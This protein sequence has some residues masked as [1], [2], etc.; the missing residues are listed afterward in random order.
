MSNVSR[1]ATA[2][3]ALLLFLLSPIGPSAADDWRCTCGCDPCGGELCVNY[4]GRCYAGE[5]WRFNL[6]EAGKIRKKDIVNAIGSITHHPEGIRVKNDKRNH[7]WT[8]SYT[9]GQAYRHKTRWTATLE[10]T[11]LSGGAWSGVG[12]GNDGFQIVFRANAH[13]KGQLVALHPDVSA[14]VV[15]TFSLPPEYRGR[16]AFTLATNYDIRTAT[17]SLSVDDTLVREIRLPDNGI[18]AIST[19]YRFCIETRNPG[20]ATTGSALYPNFHVVAYDR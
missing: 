10:V 6:Q 11:E 19:A 18:P 2:F 17:L 12:F 3:C 7:S 15:E 1:I 20:L 4:N 14:K 13:G 9:I 16:T 8:Y 5:T